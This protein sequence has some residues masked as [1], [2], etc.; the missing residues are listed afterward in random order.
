LICRKELFTGQKRST[1]P[2]GRGPGGAN[3]TG[4]FH[5]GQQP[6]PERTAAAAR[7]HGSGRRRAF[8]Q[9]ETRNRSAVDQVTVRLWSA[10]VWFCR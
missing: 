7:R 2:I 5:Q 8:G 10:S 3:L 1:S 6:I 9:E 4:G